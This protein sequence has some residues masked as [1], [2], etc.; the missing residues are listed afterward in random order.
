MPEQTLI[1]HIEEILEKKFD[2]DERA[3][4]YMK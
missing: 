4:V 3:A 2:I 1:K